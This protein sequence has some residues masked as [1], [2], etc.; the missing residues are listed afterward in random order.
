MAPQVRSSKTF[1]PNYYF[2]EQE[3]KRAMVAFVEDSRVEF[4]FIKKKK[5]AEKNDV[6][7]KSE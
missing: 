3:S 4:Q 7:I 2:R 1:Y 5:A 6:N